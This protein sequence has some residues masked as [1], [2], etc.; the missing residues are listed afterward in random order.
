MLAQ[1]WESHSIRPEVTYNVP[2]WMGKG[3]GRRMQILLPEVTARGIVDLVEQN[4]R[5]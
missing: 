1:L 5:W 4:V 2:T 3:T